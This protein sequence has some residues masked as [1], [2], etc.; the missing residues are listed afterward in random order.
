MPLV[1]RTNR[2][3]DIKVSGGFWLWCRGGTVTIG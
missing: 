2:F 3:D 1:D